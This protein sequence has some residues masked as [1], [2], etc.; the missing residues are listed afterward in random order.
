M[1]INCLKSKKTFESLNYC[2]EY[3]ET[4]F[5]LINQLKYQDQPNLASFLGNYLDKKFKDLKTSSKNSIFKNIDI[6][7]PVPVHWL[8]LFKR[9]YNHIALLAKFLAKQNTLTLTATLLKKIDL[10][11]IKCN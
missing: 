3:N 5:A 7:V 1:C 2:F 9:K 10:L 4:I 11:K 8:K 6:V